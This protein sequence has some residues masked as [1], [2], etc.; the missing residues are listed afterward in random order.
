MLKGTTYPSFLNGRT[1]WPKNE[2]LSSRGK[3]DQ[4]RD[5]EVFVVEIGVVSKDIIC[6]HQYE[7]WT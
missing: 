3:L 1:I 5:G 4:T 2:F 7:S 6:L